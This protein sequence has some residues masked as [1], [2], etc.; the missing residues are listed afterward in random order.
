MISLESDYMVENLNRLFIYEL[1][2]LFSQID[3]A[4]SKFDILELPQNIRDHLFANNK[5][6]VKYFVK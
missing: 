4:E 2:S 5:Y 6:K 1:N 3:Q